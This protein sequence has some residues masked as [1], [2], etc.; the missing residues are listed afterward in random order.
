MTANGQRRGG[1]TL[2]GELNNI[3]ATL[4]MVS[5]GHLGKPYLGCGQQTDVVINQLTPLIP[6]LDA[7]WTI[8]KAS[9][10]TPLY[11]QFGVMTSSDP[12][13]PIIVF[14]PLNNVVQ[15]VPNRPAPFPEPI[16]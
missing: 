3:M 12:N 11:H 1:D 10:F 15:T 4:N 5:G 16:K 6:K 8:D 7:T 2:N 13:D 9:D 14:D